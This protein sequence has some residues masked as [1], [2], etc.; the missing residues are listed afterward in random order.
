MKNVNLSKI[1]K[2]VVGVVKGQG[3]VVTTCW[4]TKKDVHD[5]CLGTS[6]DVRG[7]W[8]IPPNNYGPNAILIFKAQFKY[9]NIFPYYSWQSTTPL[10]YP[11]LVQSKALPYQTYHPLTLVEGKSFL[12]IFL[13]CF[14]F[15][16][17]FSKCTLIG[18]ICWQNYRVN[19]HFN[20]GTFLPIFDLK[21]IW[22]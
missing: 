3:R 4:D 10:P 21:K 20:F 6:K 16:F 1:K 5:V 8:D 7:I 14:P 9:I 17:Q 19:N 13:L 2:W 15:G 12:V 18:R 22:F 11:T